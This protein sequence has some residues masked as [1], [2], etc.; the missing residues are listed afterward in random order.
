MCVFEAFFRKAPFGGRYAVFAG[1]DEV[2][3]FLENYK[4]KPE[5]IQYLKYQFPDWKDEFL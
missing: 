5:H 2:L 3:D 4:F 1:L